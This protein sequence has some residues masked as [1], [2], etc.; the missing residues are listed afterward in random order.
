MGHE[1]ETL[2]HA[3]EGC[4]LAKPPTRNTQVFAPPFLRQIKGRTCNVT[5]RQGLRQLLQVTSLKLT[6]LACDQTH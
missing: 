3:T 1:K 6:Y 4:F 5:S 2:L